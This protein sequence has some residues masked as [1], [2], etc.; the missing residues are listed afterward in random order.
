MSYCQPCA[1]HFPLSPCFA[2]SRPTC[3]YIRSI[4]KEVKEVS[5]PRLSSPARFVLCTDTHT[6]GPSLLPPQSY[7]AFG[8]EEFGCEEE[9]KSSRFSFMDLSS[10]SET[11]PALICPFPITPYSNRRGHKSALETCGTLQDH[12]ARLRSSSKLMTKL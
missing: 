9:T 8:V 2:Q 1:L 7:H 4:R 6:L 5:A 11:F 12:G 10:G 3:F